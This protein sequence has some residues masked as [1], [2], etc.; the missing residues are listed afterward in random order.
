MSKRIETYIQ[1]FDRE[2]TCRSSSLKTFKII[3]ELNNTIKGNHREKQM[4]PH[5]STVVAPAPRLN[6]RDRRKLG[7]GG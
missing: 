2:K 6:F 1:Q 5:T 4:V 7:E 3:S